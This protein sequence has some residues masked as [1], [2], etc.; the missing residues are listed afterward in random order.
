M[1]KVL[2]P[3]CETPTL[4]FSTAPNGIFFVRR[5]QVY[6]SPRPGSWIIVFE[7]LVPDTAEEL[8]YCGYWCPGF[9]MK[10]FPLEPTGRRDH[11]RVVLALTDEA[12]MEAKL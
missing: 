9:P 5:N 11:G 2:C 8:V 3:A 12:I 6:S 4:G 1:T 10:D 7:Q